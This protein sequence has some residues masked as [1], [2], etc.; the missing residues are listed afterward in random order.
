MPSKAR[1]PAAVGSLAVVTELQ[2]CRLPVEH[3]LTGV[4]VAVSVTV[5]VFVGGGGGGGG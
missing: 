4:D 2:H 1:S 5:T 3:W